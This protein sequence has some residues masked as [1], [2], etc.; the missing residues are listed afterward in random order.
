MAD[1]YQIQDAKIRAGAHI[2]SVYPVH[3]QLN[4]ALGITNDAATIADFI[5]R[6][7]ARCDEYE[8]APNP[9]IDYSDIL[10]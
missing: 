5:T 8:A 6:V 2:L 7:K 1:Q 10:P 4:A 9:A 3:K